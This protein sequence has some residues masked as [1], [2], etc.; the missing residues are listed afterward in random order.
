[1]LARLMADPT[2]SGTQAARDGHIVVLEYRVFLPISPFARFLVAALA[3]AL[4]G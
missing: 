3:E 1:M 2:I 4:Y